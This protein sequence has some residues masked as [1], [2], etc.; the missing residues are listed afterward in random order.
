[1]KLS[2]SKIEAFVAVAQTGNITLAAKRLGKDRSTLSQMVAALEDELGIALFER[3][4]KMPV[5]TEP[6]Q[7]LLGRARRLCA[8]ADAFQEYALQMSRDAHPTLTL[9]VSPLIPAR[10]VTQAVRHWRQ[11]H[12]GTQLEVRSLDIDSIRQQ[13]LTQQLDVGLTLNSNPTSTFPMV[14]SYLANL[15][16][17]FVASVDA[18]LPIRVDARQLAQVR[19][20]CH[21]ELADSAQASLLLVGR[22]VEV[23]GSLELLVEMVAADLGW[24]VLPEAVAQP[25]LERGQL[26]RLDV[27]ELVR[28]PVVPVSLWLA[29]S[30]AELPV[31]DAFSQ[32]VVHCAEQ[33]GL[34]GG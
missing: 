11:S 27:Q 1:M 6:G 34:D 28:Q 29:P 14:A 10:L 25:Y 26:R 2:L 16:M 24:S 21:Q 19:Q 18:S 33:L 15:P 31:I 8:E 9:G 30:V 32:S 23:I 17:A 12:P 13:L 22:S 4:G 5:L 3:S 7:S 20:L